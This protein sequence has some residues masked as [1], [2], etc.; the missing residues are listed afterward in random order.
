MPNEMTVAEL[1]RVVNEVFTGAFGATPL[2]ERLKDIAGEVDELRRY[3]GVANIQ[4]ELGDALASLLQL[5]NECEWN[6]EDLVARTL[7]KIERRRTQYAA[8]GRKKRIA[9]FGGA[10]DPIHAGHIAAAKL[11]L[12]ASKYFDEIWLMPSYRHMDGKKMASPKHRLA[13]CKL[14]AEVDFRIKAFD[15]EIENKLAGETYHFAKRLMAEDFAKDKYDFSFV[16]GL[17][18][19]NRLMDWPNSESL[20]GMM[21]FIVISRAGNP[22]VIDSW[23]INHPHRIIVDDKNLIPDISSTRVR[24]MIAV[25]DPAV[26]QK[27]DPQVLAYI[28]KRGL[29][30]RVD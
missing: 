3:T 10:F 14:A 6:A 24:R 22:L 28:E 4:E 1:Q 13:M 17:D 23:Y 21:K 29:Y 30:R 26:I 19:A 25:S 2:V 15:Y 18:V 9:I 8:L 11:I 16:L 5:A 12:D 27:L 7:A 20:E